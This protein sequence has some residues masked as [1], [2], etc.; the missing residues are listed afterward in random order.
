MEPKNKPSFSYF[1]GVVLV[2]VTVA[3]WILEPVMSLKLI[4]IVI[5]LFLLVA[6]GL[7]GIAGSPSKH[8][9]TALAALTPLIEI[10]WMIVYHSGTYFL[11]FYYQEYWGSYA[12]CC[13]VIPAAA[14]IVGTK[15]G[16]EM[17]TREDNRPI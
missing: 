7:A 10:V 9:F 14:F 5:Y 2:T 13:L 4:P 17:E 3:V 16:P 1:L 11:V 6:V 12:V 8:L 15:L